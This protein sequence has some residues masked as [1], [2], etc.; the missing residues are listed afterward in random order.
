[1]KKF[2]IQIHALQETPMVF[3]RSVDSSNSGPCKKQNFSKTRHDGDADYI[4]NFRHNK[5]VTG[6]NHALT[7]L[8]ILLWSQAAIIRP[9]F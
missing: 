4:I 5:I 2:A 1:V 9:L 8:G 6:K 3:S 7:V